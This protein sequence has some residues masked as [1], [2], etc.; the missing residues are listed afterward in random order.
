MTTLDLVTK[1]CANCGASGMYVQISSTN[2]FGAPDLDLRPPPRHRS[3]MDFWIEACSD[4][5]YCASDISELAPGVVEI[6]GSDE[7][8]RQFA[9][10]E[11]PE[12]ANRF[13]CHAMVQERLEDFA[14][15]GLSS[16]YAVW[17]LDD[18]EQVDHAKRYRQ[19]AVSLLQQAKERGQEFADD[20]DSED[21][22]LVDL[23]RRSEQFDLALATCDAVLARNPDDVIASVVRFQKSLIAERNVDGYTIQDALQ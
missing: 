14:Q 10:P 9:D 6:I 23:L 7:Y 19:Q 20:A 11:L 5:T 12:Q 8:Q 3:T 22:M 13:L 15:A 18:A 2:M 16:I 1:T 17:S 4:C 21:A